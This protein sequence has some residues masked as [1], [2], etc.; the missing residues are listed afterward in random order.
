MDVSIRPATIGDY[1]DIYALWNGSEQSRR[2]LNPVDDSREGIGRYMRRNPTT[3]FVACGEEGRGEIVGVILAGHDGRRGLI[4]HL[5]VCP[6]YRSRGIAGR[7]V[8]RAEE[9]LRAEGITKVFCLV[10]RDNN[11]ADEFWEKQGY[12]LRTNI[13]Y[14]NKSLDP[15]VPRGE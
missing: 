12:S 4:H 6:D 2:A 5:C 15:G 7:L 14:R 11:A 3:C 13:H 1:E 9:A 8:R 10:F